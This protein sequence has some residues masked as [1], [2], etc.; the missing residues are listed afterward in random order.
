VTVVALDNHRRKIVVAPAPAIIALSLAKTAKPSF[1][2]S[3]GSFFD[4]SALSSARNEHWKQSRRFG[5][6]EHDPR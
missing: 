6:R 5:R 1:R 4:N 3:V 2:L